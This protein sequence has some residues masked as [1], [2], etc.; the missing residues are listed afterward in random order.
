M[1]H[2]LLSLRFGLARQLEAYMSSKLTTL[3]CVFVAKCGAH[4]CGSR[5]LVPLV[6]DRR[7]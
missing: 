1:D 4:P 6:A 5:S 7:G 2:R 3:Q